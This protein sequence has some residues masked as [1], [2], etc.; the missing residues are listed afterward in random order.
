MNKF[1]CKHSGNNSLSRKV[2]TVA[3][4]MNSDLAIHRNRSLALRGPGFPAVKRSSD[5]RPAD[6]CE[7]INNIPCLSQF[8][9]PHYST[10]IV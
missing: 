8:E 9:S 1:V 6:L 7:R 5:G 2:F 10:A 4:V 3:R